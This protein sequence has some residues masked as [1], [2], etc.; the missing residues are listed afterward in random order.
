MKKRIPTLNEFVDQVVRDK[1]ITAIPTSGGESFKEIM[2]VLEFEHTVGNS[3][4]TSLEHAL[5]VAF[6]N[7][8]SVFRIEQDYG[9]VGGMTRAI[10]HLKDVP[11]VQTKFDS[12][13]GSLNFHVNL[14]GAKKIS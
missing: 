4:Y 13:I 8:N 14:I 7:D 5:S 3:N 12:A 9:E 6:S 10:V 11:Q 2:F 1:R